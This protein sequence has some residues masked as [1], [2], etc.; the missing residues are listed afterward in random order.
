M[1]NEPIYSRILTAN[2]SIIQIVVKRAPIPATASRKEGA[3]PATILAAHIMPAITQKQT[4]SPGKN[5]KQPPADR[6]VTGAFAMKTTARA[7][8]WT[9]PRFMTAFQGAAYLR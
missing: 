6:V 9:T 3:I 5:A 1:Q 4:A 2:S 7:G 8:A